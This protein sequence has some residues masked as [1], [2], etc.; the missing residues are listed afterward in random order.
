MQDKDKTKVVPENNVHALEDTRARRSESTSLTVHSHQIKNMA[1]IRPLSQ[2]ELDELKIIYAGMNNRQALNA[3]REIRTRI[4]QHAENEN[5]VL[6]ITAVGDEGGASFASINLGAAVALDRSK[7]AIVVDCNLH[8][9]SL[10]KLLG[11]RP[12]FGMADY[13]ED[14]SVSVDDII[15]ASGV[16]RL[17][18]IPAGKECE[19]G[20][21]LFTSVR[22]KEM[23]AELKTRYADRFVILDAPPIT[24]S[25]DS[26]ILQELCDFIVLVVPYGKVTNAQVMAAIDAIDRKRLV[27]VIFN[28]F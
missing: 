18:V 12:E 22:M 6:M 16:S 19:P 26:R 17:R 3:F 25:A 23:L 8:H 5:F 28:D 2:S 10:Q 4:F 7:S 14:T 24:S 15:Y 21:E 13:L 27:G 1:D 9:P 11:H 20:V